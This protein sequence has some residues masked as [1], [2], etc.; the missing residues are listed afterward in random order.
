MRDPTR[1]RSGVGRSRRGP[2]QRRLQP[3]QNRRPELG[4]RAVVG[5]R[6]ENRNPRV[7]MHGPGPA[8][9][10]VRSVRYPPDA[11]ASACRD[12]LFHE[13]TGL[14]AGSEAPATH[15]CHFG[16]TGSTPA[17]RP[18][19]HL[20][21]AIRHRDTNAGTAANRTTR[22]HDLRTSSTHR[23][24]VR[25][26][27]ARARSRINPALAD[28]RSTASAW[29]WCARRRRVRS[30]GCTRAVSIRASKVFTLT[31]RWKRGRRL[32]RGDRGAIRRP[33]QLADPAGVREGIP[34]KPFMNAVPCHRASSCRTSTMP[35]A[36]CRVHGARGQSRS[37][38]SE[39]IARSSAR[40]DTANVALANL[41]PQLR[42]P[43]QRRRRGA[44]LLLPA[45][46]RC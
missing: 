11:R 26:V 4:E 45:S 27:S 19:V 35:K 38:H 41:H 6:R 1:G 22:R 44:R 16:A 29:R 24:E 42:Q 30:R 18:P 31:W 17:S 12:G 15:P 43:A 8:S 33:V 37:G 13:V 34:R 32:C 3:R 5:V 14:R 36:R 9:I 21:P 40:V 28:G 39:V 7:V 20:S 46:V 2:A 10:G 23:A 25:D